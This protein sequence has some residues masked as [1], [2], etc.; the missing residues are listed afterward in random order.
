M[1]EGIV[2]IKKEFIHE[3]D[4]RSKVLSFHVILSHSKKINEMLTEL[5]INLGKTC[6]NKLQQ[7]E[8]CQSTV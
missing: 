6:S 4:V 5:N 7:N 2:E 8:E 1:Y 3:K